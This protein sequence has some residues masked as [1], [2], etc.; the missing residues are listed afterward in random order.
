MTKQ[1]ILSNLCYHDKRNPNYSG[2]VNKND[3]YCD[4]CFRGKTE[5]AEELLKCMDILKEC[6][7][8]I[9]I[10]TNQTSKDTS[11]NGRLLFE[12]ENIIK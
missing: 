12:I 7:N 11:V 4:N 9:M 3:C 2:G 8:I 5:L 6:R 10:Y 1:E